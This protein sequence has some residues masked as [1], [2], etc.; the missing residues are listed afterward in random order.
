MHRVEYHP[1]TRLARYAEI[2]L[3]ELD[4]SKRTICL[5]PTLRFQFKGLGYGPPVW[6]QG[7]WQGELATGHESFDPA[8]LNLLA[9]ENVHVQQ[10]MRAT[11]GE[12]TGIGVLEQIVIGP[13][14]PA[15]FKDLLDGAS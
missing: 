2:D 7:A 11:D 9:P 3:I 10:V 13:Y 4:G 15:G 8:E 6:K 1:G 12:R 14:E 5:E